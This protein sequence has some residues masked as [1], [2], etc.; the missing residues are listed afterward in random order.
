MA[1]NDQTRKETEDRLRELINGLSKNIDQ[2]DLSLLLD[3]VEN[4]EYGVALEW[5]HNLVIERG[6]LLSNEQSQLVEQLA[7]QMNIR[8]QTNELR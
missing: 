6:I 3:F 7:R 5:L 1:I 8:L 2:D 4:R